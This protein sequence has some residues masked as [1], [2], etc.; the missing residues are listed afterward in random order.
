M[1]QDRTGPKFVAHRAISKLRAY[2][3]SPYK[4]RTQCR[5]SGTRVKGGEKGLV[6]Y[7]K[8]NVR[9]RDNAMADVFPH[10]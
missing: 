2:L 6:G 8:Y 4:R 9:P 1:P 10:P 5:L 3:K 7:A